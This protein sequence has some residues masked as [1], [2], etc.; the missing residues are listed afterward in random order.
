[1]HTYKV[2]VIGP[3]RDPRDNKSAAKFTRIEN[4]VA[5]NRQQASIIAA[6]K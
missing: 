5:A 4:V 6:N 2:F 3:P 1:M